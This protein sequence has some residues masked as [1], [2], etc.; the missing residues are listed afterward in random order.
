MTTKNH[1]NQRPVD[2]FA[3]LE[4]LLFVAL[5][6]VYVWVIQPTRNDWIRTPY[7]ALVVLIPFASNLIHGDRLRDIG[8]RFDNLPASARDVGLATLFGGV[9]VIAIS[10]L[11]GQS[12]SLDREVSAAFFSYPLW[13]LAQQYAMQS[14]TLRRI[15]GAT[16][17]KRGAAAG[18]ALLFAFLH[19]PNLALAIVT[20]V[21]G[22]VWCR[23]F[24]RHP[25]L[26]TLALSHGWLAVLL[27]YSWPADWIHNLR[28]GPSFWT[29]TP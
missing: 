14:F 16:G 15:F 21:G 18:T 25:N 27:R 13:G 17:H 23:L 12:P 3:I 22:Y 9:L 6:I 4:P 5:A 19:W 26:L 7:M 10:L 29:W 20:L 8:L 28:I 24:I 2:R 11:A 1:G